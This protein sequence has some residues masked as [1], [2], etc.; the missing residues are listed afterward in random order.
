MSINV[1]KA[2]VWPSMK[3]NGEMKARRPCNIMRRIHP[4]EENKAAKAESWPG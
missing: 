2:A 3:A 1:M 4:G